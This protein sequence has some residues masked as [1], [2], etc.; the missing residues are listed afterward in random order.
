MELEQIILKFIWNHKRPRTAK[1]ILRKKNKAEGITLLDY[2]QY[3][4]STTYKL[5]GC[6]LSKIWTCIHMPNPIR[7]EWNCSLPSVSYC[8]Q[9][10][11]C[12]SSYPL[13]FQSV[14]LLAVPLMSTLICQLLYYTMILFK[15]LYCK[16]KYDRFIFCFLCI[17]CVKNW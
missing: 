15:V 16:I 5:S 2:R 11:S 9:S 17:I 7:R 6:E 8:W 14:T 10:F 3:N 12:I 4:K 1:A 13:S